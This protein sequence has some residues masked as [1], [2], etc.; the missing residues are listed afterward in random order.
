MKWDK[1]GWGDAMEA[2]SGYFTK[3]IR[4]TQIVA[5]PLASNA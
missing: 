2:M 3:W 5:Q 4:Q 1:T